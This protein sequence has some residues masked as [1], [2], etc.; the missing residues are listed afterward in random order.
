MKQYKPCNG[1]IMI[2]TLLVIAALMVIVTYVGYRGALYAPFST[3]IVA[4]EKAKLVTLGGIQVAIA[5]LAYVPPK[6]EQKAAAQQGEAEQ[7]AEGKES[8]GADQEI[9]D[10][11]TRLLPT[12]NRW[13]HFELSQATDGI[14]AVL[15]VCV[16]CEEGKINLNRIFSFKKEDFRGDKQ[17]GWKTIMP[18]LFKVVEKFTKTTELFPAFEKIM[19]ARTSKFND[20]SELI[21][22]KEFAYFKDFLF[23][24]PSLSEKNVADKKQQRPIYLLDIFTVWSSS[25]TL[26]P[27]FF[28]DSINALLGLPQVTGGDIKVRQESIE[29]WLKNFKKSFDWKTDWNAVLQPVYGKELRTLP[30]NIDSMLSTTSDPRFFSVLVQGKV[31]DIMQ[32]A[33]AIL[34]RIKRPSEGDTVVYDIVIKKLYWL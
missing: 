5:Q 16:M 17:T 11:L 12:L 4:R 13:Q 26:D 7:K 10:L 22:N 25:D 23:Y 34:E 15:D 9:K 14:D 6:K 19:K 27:W 20:A 32:K 1:Y 33:Y 18:E 30:K 28:S 29:N 2:F 24:E 8:S 31:G 21:T 3:M